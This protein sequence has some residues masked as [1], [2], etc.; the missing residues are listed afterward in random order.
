MH[1][2]QHQYNKSQ[3]KK[4]Y[5]RQYQDYHHVCKYWVERDENTKATLHIHTY[6][7]ARHIP[8]EPL[9]PCVADSGRGNVLMLH[10]SASRLLPYYSWMVGKLHFLWGRLHQ[11]EGGAGR[12]GCCCIKGSSLLLKEAHTQHTKNTKRFSLPQL[13]LAETF[14]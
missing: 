12:W 11:W 7:M 1:C 13:A 10:C 5:R 8:A 4:A 9:W 2:R 6:A 3:W 14:R